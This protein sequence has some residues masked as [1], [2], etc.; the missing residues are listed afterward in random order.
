M[1]LIPLADKSYKLER[2]SSK[3]SRKVLKFSRRLNKFK[4]RVL[5][6]YFRWNW[7]KKLNFTGTKKLG[8]AHP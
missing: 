1:I 4:K 6:N 3:M 2:N 7:T 5:K 8:T